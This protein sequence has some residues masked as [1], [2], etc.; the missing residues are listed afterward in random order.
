VKW[1]ELRKQVASSDAWWRDEPKVPPVIY[2]KADS[3][4]ILAYWQRLTGGG[5]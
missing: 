4:F 5:K 1:A 3:K 2:T